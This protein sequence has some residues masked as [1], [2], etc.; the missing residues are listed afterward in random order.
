MMG[1][2]SAKAAQHAA[3][4]RRVDDWTPRP[5]SAAGKNANTFFSTSPDVNSARD[6]INNI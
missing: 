5:P 2:A 4:A 3:G 6:I 1:K